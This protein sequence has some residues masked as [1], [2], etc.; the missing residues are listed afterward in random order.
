MRM[1]FMSNLCANL[2]MGLAAATHFHN[3]LLGVSVG[4]NMLRWYKNFSVAQVS[5]RVWP[6]IGTHRLSA[7]LAEAA[8][9]L[10]SA[11]VMNR[12]ANTGDTKANTPVCTGRCLPSTTRCASVRLANCSGSPGKRRWSSSRVVDSPMPVSLSPRSVDPC[13]D[14]VGELWLTIVFDGLHS[15]VPLFIN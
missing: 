5:C 1:P 2:M 11:A 6:V 14:I 15:K 12:S 13:L 8:A 3:C 10:S 7:L 9:A 4:L